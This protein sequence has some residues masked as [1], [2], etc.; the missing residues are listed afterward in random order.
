M[1]QSTFLELWGVL[2]GSPSLSLLPTRGEHEH[3]AHVPGRERAQA[4]P[5]GRSLNVC[6]L[7]SPGAG[8]GTGG[9][10]EVRSIVVATVAAA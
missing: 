7:H 2:S 10:T 9:G 1:G 6:L 5:G 3:P 4:T 8:A